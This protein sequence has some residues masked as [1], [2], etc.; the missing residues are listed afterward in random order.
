LSEQPRP[1]HRLYALDMRPICAITR[2]AKLTARAADRADGS[3]FKD[4]ALR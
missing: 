1:R 2:M 4:A 3:I